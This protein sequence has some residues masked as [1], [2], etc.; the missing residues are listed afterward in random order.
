MGIVIY[1]TNGLSVICWRFNYNLALK[2]YIKLFTRL[3]SKAL[4]LLK[5]LFFI[6]NISS[7]LI[8]IQ[9]SSQKNNY[10]INSLQADFITYSEFYKKVISFALRKAKVVAKLTLKIT[11]EFINKLIKRG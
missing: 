3:S 11:N 7:P 1:S 4:K 9:F 6:F 8:F 5:Q 2:I 10:T